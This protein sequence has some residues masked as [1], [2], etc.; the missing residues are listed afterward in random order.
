MSVYVQNDKDSS[1]TTQK[2]CYDI[3][4][5]TEIEIY[6]QRRMEDSYTLN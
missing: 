5:L 1:A 6:N 2:S 3:T 4:T